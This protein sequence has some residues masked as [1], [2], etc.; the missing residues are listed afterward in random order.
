M[1]VFP[2]FILAQIASWA[3]QDAAADDGGDKI[4]IDGHQSNGMYCVHQAR[5]MIKGDPTVYRIIIAPANAPIF[6]NDDKRPVADAFA[7]PLGDS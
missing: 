6:I 3:R 2:G 1:T 5:A 4:T 7:L